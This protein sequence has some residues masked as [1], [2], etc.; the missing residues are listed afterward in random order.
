MWTSE[1]VSAH[2]FSNP[3]AS[4]LF[5][6]HFLF[7]GVSPIC[8]LEIVLF[9]VFIL[10][11]W[12]HWKHKAWFS[13]SDNLKL[14]ESFTFDSGTFGLVVA[15]SRFMTNC[16][17]QHWPDFSWLWYTVYKL[18]IMRTLE[19]VRQVFRNWGCDPVHL[20]LE[21]IYL[22]LLIWVSS[23]YWKAS[24]EHNYL[25]DMTADLVLG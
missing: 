4:G 16:P 13:L 19:V 20:C 22:S 3:S 10:L 2:I 21:F 23:P 1:E 24:V 17:D 6:G 18:F 11:L 7:L 25:G 9:V 5:K 15:T 14:S 12:A 8:L